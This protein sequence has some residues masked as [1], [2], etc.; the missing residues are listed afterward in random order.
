MNNILIA[1][2][3][4]FIAQM[5]SIYMS[6]RN[7]KGKILSVQIVSM[8]LLSLSSFLLK[9]YSAV[10]IDALAIVRNIVVLKQIQNRYL[11]LSFVILTVVL[12]VAFNNRGF[13]GL[14][15]IVA[16]VL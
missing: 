7:N 16:N 12:G 9:G 8:V 6:T 5:I 15:P 1:N 14:L 3:L 11:D 2:I 10:V 4:A 13:I